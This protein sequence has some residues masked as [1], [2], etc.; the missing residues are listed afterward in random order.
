M[1]APKILVT[2]VRAYLAGGLWIFWNT[3]TSKL[4]S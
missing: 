1:S 2:G 4:G 3:Q